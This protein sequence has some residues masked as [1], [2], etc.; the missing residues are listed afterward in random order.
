MSGKM[1]AA[2]LLAAASDDGER[3]EAHTYIGFDDALAGRRDSAI[4]HFRWVKDKGSRNFVEFPIAAA[5]L[6]R[7]EKAP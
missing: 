3:T 5:E 1:P 7:L 6:K 2:A 4:A